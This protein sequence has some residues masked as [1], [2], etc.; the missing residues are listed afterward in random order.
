MAADIRQQQ[1]KRSVLSLGSK[2]PMFQFARTCTGALFED[3]W[4]GT[5]RVT[6]HDPRWCSRHTTV[7]DRLVVCIGAILSL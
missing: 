6:V 1:V 5:L 4:R 2:T 3:S 7:T